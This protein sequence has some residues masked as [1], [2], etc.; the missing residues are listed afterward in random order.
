[1]LPFLVEKKKIAIVTAEDEMDLEK[2]NQQS[3]QGLLV[4]RILAFGNGTL[5]SLLT[6]V[7]VFT[8]VRLFWKQ[9]MYRQIESMIPI[10]QIR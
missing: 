5:K 2:K 10:W 1:M 6:G 8:D 3:Y 9:K 4:C 7:K